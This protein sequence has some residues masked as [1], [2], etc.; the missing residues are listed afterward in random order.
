MGLFNLFG[1]TKSQAHPAEIIK[2]I[3]KER[4]TANVNYERLVGRASR[5]KPLIAEGHPK[6]KALQKELDEIMSELGI[7]DQ[8]IRKALGDD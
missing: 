7:R 2:I 6:A 5:I 8:A 4:P 3:E 1:R